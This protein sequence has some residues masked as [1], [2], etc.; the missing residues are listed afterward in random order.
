MSLFGWV[1]SSNLIPSSGLQPGRGVPG[2]GAV[3]SPPRHA[4]PWLG[5][6]SGDNNW[7]TCDYKDDLL[8]EGMRNDLLLALSSRASRGR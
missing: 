2:R 7:C 4:R 6:E 5:N 8:R 3:G 1:R